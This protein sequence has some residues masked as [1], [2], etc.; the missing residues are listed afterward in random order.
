MAS[1]DEY[2]MDS[3]VT[4]DK[5]KLLTYDL[6]LCETWKDNVLP[7]IKKNLS[8]IDSMRSYMAVSTFLE[9]NT[10]IIAVS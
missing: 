1:T 9:F 4:F 6:L 3:F 5:M 10:V 2:V 8:D 7:I